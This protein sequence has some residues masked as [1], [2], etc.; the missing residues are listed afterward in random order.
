MFLRTSVAAAS[1]SGESSSDLG[2]MTI[3]DDGARN[4]HV[5]PSPDGR[6]VAF[7]SDRD[8]ERGVYIARRDGTNVRRISGAGYA[9]VPA[10]AP[11]GRRIAYVRAEADNPR[12]WNLWLQGVDQGEARRLTTY[13]RGQAWSASWFPDNRRLSYSYDDTLVILDVESG[14]PRVTARRSKG[15]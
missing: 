7:D 10:W 8:G 11:D 3:A 14:A 6:L 9:A 15:G 5:Q 2:V 1:P 13:Q 4:Y 12:V